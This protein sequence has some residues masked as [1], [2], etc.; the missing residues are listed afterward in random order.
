MIVGQ[1]DSW[2]ERFEGSVWC[3]VFEALENLAVDTPDGKIPIQG[4]DIF[5]V[6]SQYETRPADDPKIEAHREYLDLQ[7]AIAGHE[8]FDWYP[9]AQ[10]NDVQMPYDAE[11][12]VMLFNPPEGDAPCRVD[13]KDGVYALVFPEDVHSPQNSPGATPQTVKKVVAKIR[14]S[15]LEKIS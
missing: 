4:D 8:R 13:L 2:R 11:R 12:D 10:M 15:L 3:K 9:L 1:L 6:V 5:L 14:A 7:M